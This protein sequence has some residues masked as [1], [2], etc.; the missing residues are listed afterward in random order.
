MKPNIHPQY[1]QDAVVTCACGA[2]WQTGSTKKDIRIEICGNCHPFY[3]GKQKLV[4]TLGRVDKFRTRT[5]QATTTPTKKKAEARTT[6]ISATAI[7]AAMKG[8]KAVKEKKVVGKDKEK[9]D[10]KDSKKK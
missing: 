3:T 2:T 6:K 7:R 4:D 9:A 10:K 8:A 5:A 1:H